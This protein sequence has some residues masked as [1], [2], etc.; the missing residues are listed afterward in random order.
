MW[1]Q[2]DIGDTTVPSLSA[3]EGTSDGT[4]S[5]GANVVATV[6]SRSNGAVGVGEEHVDES[7]LLITLV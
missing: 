1:T 3:G 7:L 4:V 2:D 6:A 5:S